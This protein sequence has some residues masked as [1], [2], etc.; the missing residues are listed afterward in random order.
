MG[1]TDGKDA[2]NTIRMGFTDTL[3]VSHSTWELTER[4]FVM[5]KT[6]YKGHWAWLLLIYTFS[7]LMCNHQ[8]L[9][10]FTV[11]TVYV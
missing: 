1:F 2:S 11:D 9:E 8:V 3:V 7:K 5:D 4:R 6:L 10:T